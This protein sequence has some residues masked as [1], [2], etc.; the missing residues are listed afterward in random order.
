MHINICFR[1]VIFLYAGVDRGKKEGKNLVATIP[2]EEV[3]KER[4]RLEYCWG[5]ESLDTTY[6]LCLLD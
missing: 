4:E 1:S 2:S 6:K 3:G 5:K